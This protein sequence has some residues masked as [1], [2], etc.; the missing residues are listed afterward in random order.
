MRTVPADDIAFWSTT[1]QAAAVRA[2]EFSA[3]ALLELYAARI[4][5]LNTVINAI[6]T[7]DLDRASRDAATIDERLARGDD[8]G[9]LA[10]IPMTIK[11]A[12]AVAGIP[13]TGGAIELQDHVPSGDAPAVAAL[14]AAGAVIM[15]KTNVPRWC[16]AETE[17]HNELF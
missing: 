10:G 17:T 6:V 1:R 9:P 4:D 3:H 11:D 15:G 8:V 5:R 7:L 12:I 14:R 13:S 16:N 2:R